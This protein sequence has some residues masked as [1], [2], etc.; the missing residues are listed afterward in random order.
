M[1]Y[2]IAYTTHFRSLDNTLWEIVISIDRPD[3]FGTP[4]VEIS[5]EGDE[6]CVI[7][8]QETGKNDVV[9]S[10]TCTLRVSNESDRQ[11]VQLMNHRAAAVLVSRNGKAYWLG[12]LDDSIYE[13]PYSFTKAYMTELTFSDF[14]VLNR[15]L[16]TLTGKQSVG[17][18]VRDCL[19]SIGYG[20]GDTINLYTSLLEPKTQQP[21][22]L[23]MLYINADRF[24]AESDS[25]GA[26]TTKREVLEEILRPLGLRIMQKN[27]QIYI[28]DMEYLRDHDNFN[29]YI[30]WKGTDAYLKGSE[31]FGWY[32]VAFEPNAEETL[33]D[34]GLDYDS[35]VWIDRKRYLAYSYDEETE[36]DSDVGFYVEFQFYPPHG[37]KVQKSS[38][39]LFFRTR[40]VFTDSSDIGVAWRIQCKSIDGYYNNPIFGLLPLVSDVVLVDNHPA[41]SLS[42]TET[43]F[44]LETGYLPITPDRDNYQLRVNL[45]FLL[46]FR[47][48]PL[49]DPPDEWVAH[50]EWY[51]GNYD[52][53]EMRWRRQNFFAHMVPVI[54]EVVDE[55]GNAIFHYKNAVAEDVDKNYY[56]NIVRVAKVTPHGIGHGEWVS[57][58]ASW[59][60]MFLAY[61]KDYNP[62]DTDR[63]PLVTSGWVGN[64]IALSAIKE[65]N[66]TLYRVR[67]DGEYLPLPPV[68]GRLRLTV[69]SG[70]FPFYPDGT[71]IV[72][73]ASYHWM[74]WQL[75]RNPKITMVKADRK[76]DGISTGTVYER[77]MISHYDDHLS[78]TMKV[79]T[80]CK[81][82]APSARGLFFDAN[83]TVWE[84][85]IKNGAKDTLERHR[86]VCL[87]DQN[88]DV[89]PV[90]SGTAELDIR[91]CAKCEGST[92]GIFLVTALRQNL[93][94]DTE[95][96][97]MA[98]IANAS[99]FFYD[100]NW[101]EPICVQVEDVPYNF[102]WSEPICVQIEEKPEKDN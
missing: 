71:V 37:T 84:K 90:L 24:A 4:P 80:W 93:Q 60:D 30:V 101:S 22:T 95:Q 78:E 12:H 74:S 53:N 35:Y 27:G 25:W 11:M 16:F 75:Y 76:D 89:Q 63:D 72:N 48:N 47:D 41:K 99:H 98:R 65:I 91:F 40:S 23:D 82:I 73:P 7:E 97:T 85:F 31:T 70:V 54:L 19:D 69:G 28:Y 79:G 39:A 32:D 5:L 66:G 88:S 42:Q 83:G 29:N 100:Y 38:D 56:G 18:I 17:A 55:N 94:Q 14:G 21:I 13:E 96:V 67:D 58:A 6:P 51:S 61:Y 86:L 92:P 36:T 59:A 9:Q 87:E 44:S 10:S 50:Q 43:V 15:I 8:W 3:G 102:A 46:S 77:D 62:D 68:A 57:G 34:D 52:A 33:A 49:D 2:Q 1:S 64:R 81:G 26:K 45:D 20:N